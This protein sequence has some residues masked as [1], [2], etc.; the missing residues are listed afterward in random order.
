MD[1]MI[2]KY[3]GGKGR[4]G[5][6]D[7]LRLLNREAF[8]KISNPRLIIVGGPRTGKTTLARYLGVGELYSTDDLIGAL[9]WSA[10]WAEVAEWI[11]RPGPW[12]I[13]GVASVRALRKWLRQYQ[14]DIRPA[15]AIL[16]LSTPV[17]QQSEGQQRMARS[18]MTIWREIRDELVR[19]G[20][21]VIEE[22]PEF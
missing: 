22:G 15:E 17:C 3:F 21:V 11:H 10:A 16:Y 12:T 7:F 8:L 2:T 18:C 9:D 13:E 19:R 5:E 4:P 6:C 20:A 1:I 14:G